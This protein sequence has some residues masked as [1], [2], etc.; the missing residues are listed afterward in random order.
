MMVYGITLN[1]VSIEEELKMTIK[2]QGVF[3]EM[4]NG[5]SNSPSVFDFIQTEPS[6]YEERIINYLKNGIVVV[7][8]GGI[9]EDVINPNNG[10]AGCPDLKTDGVWAWSGELEY[11]VRTYHLK[12]NDD[13]IQTMKINDWIIKS[14]LEIDYDDIHII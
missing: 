10:F 1:Q 13:F 14:N 5:N 3:K 6:E 8:C 11:Y 7:A 4:L 2:M 12:L 9:V